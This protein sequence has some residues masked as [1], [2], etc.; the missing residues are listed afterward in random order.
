MSQGRIVTKTYDNLI[1]GLH[2]ENSILKDNT[3]YDIVEVDGQLM[4]EELG[5]HFNDFD[6]SYRDLDIT[7]LTLGK[8]LV[9]TDYEMEDI[10]EP[11]RQTSPYCEDYVPLKRL[12]GKS[13]SSLLQRKTEILLKGRNK[14]SEDELEELEY[15]KDTLGNTTA[16][17]FVYDRHYAQFL[18]FIA[19]NNHIDFDKYTH[20]S[21]EEMEELLEDFKDYFED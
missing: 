13:M 20:I 14:Q 10:D 5:E 21:E 12:C 7:F 19:D 3:V 6:N 1:V 4:L 15:I 2:S 18:Q 8:N 16:T 9:G 11:C 17:N